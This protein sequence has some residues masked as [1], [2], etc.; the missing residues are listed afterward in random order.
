MSAFSDF[1]ENF[2]VNGIFRGAGMVAP[3]A[4]YLGLTSGI[5]VDSAPQ[6]T[7]PVGIGNYTR[8]AFGPPSASA[9]I[10]HNVPTSGQIYLGSGITPISNWTGGNT[11]ISGAFI[12]M[13]STGS[14]VICY[15]SLT[16]PKLIT[17]SDSL[18]F[19][20]GSISFQIL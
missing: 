19:A 15:G 7:E 6:L 4:L 5:P 12:A 16:T 8:W 13:S 18:S 3:T 11:A 10:F 2:L 1:Y 20:S 14:D 17:N 9:F